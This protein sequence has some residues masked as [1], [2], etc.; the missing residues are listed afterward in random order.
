M[1][2][3]KKQKK[4]KELFVSKITVIIQVICTIISLSV[5]RSALKFS[6]ETEAKAESP[7]LTIGNDKKIEIITYIKNN[8]L[9]YC[10]YN[11]DYEDQT[12][13]QKTKE[14]MTLKL[15][16]RNIG[17]SPAYRIQIHEYRVSFSENDDSEIQF[18]D[19][20]ILYIKENLSHFFR[21]ANFNP[22][23]ENILFFKLDK[24]KLSAT[25][26]GK[27][28]RLFYK[29]FYVM[30]LYRTKEYAF[31]KSDSDSSLKYDIEFFDDSYEKKLF[32]LYKEYQVSKKM[33]ENSR[34]TLPVDT[35]F[36]YKTLVPIIY[37]PLVITY[38]N[39]YGAQF[40]DDCVLVF[41]ME[42]CDRSNFHEQ[43]K[44]HMYGKFKLLDKISRKHYFKDHNFI[45]SDSIGR[46]FP[47]KI[48]S[49]FVSKEN[50]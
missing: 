7:Y 38:N 48:E 16:L 35:L 36:D 2:I 27:I 28:I 43:P 11:P 31:L 24:L 40:E 1:G 32:E 15:D 8:E 30:S 18:K 21:L 9:Q 4:E 34:I 37:I 39:I 6:I 13:S 19:N 44:F 46:D 23:T 41:E 45:W 5:A 10:F 47:H 26:A 49:D 17:N 20:G 3:K 14:D 29:P 33:Q 22:L 25:I 42:S 12:I 50:H